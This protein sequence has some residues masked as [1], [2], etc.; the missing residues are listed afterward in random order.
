MKLNLFV[1]VLIIF[2][3]SAKLNKTGEKG[4]FDFLF[5]GCKKCKCGIPNRDSR[6]LGGEYLRTYEFPWMSIINY[7]G[8]VSPGVLINDRYVLTAAN[9]VIGLSP[10]DMKVTLGAFD[11]CFPDQKSTNVSV[12]KIIVNPAF[13]PGNRAND[14]ALIRLSSTV[15]FE[16]SI[17][18]ICL[19]A[20]GFNYL[21]QVATVVG[22]AEAQTVEGPV[23]ASCRPRKSGLPVL[24]H[25]ECLGTAADPQ[26]YSA[27]K[28]C[29]GVI[30]APSVVCNIDGGGPVM[31]RSHAGVYELIGVLSDQNDCSPRPSTA[32]YT[33]I[34][35]HL[36]WITENT[37]DAC[38]CYKT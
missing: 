32:L 7:R 38:Y 37:K 3:V 19:S 34:N 17:S 16:Q 13:S 24:G 33:N 36:Q 4:I 22:W 14:L 21:G 18:P 8:S 1:L 27:D 10:L 25:D 30:G 23:I 9:Q 6:L 31:Y 28:G 26:Y 20:P 5:N 2:E 11:R 15:V 12:D 35:Q 29:V